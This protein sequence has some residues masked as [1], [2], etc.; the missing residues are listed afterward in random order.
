MIIYISLRMFVDTYF[1]FIYEKFFT[2]LIYIVYK[3]CNLE[4]S[5]K[6]S[7]VI[8]ISYAH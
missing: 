7:N 4:D 6:S 3:F 8:F 2:G 5:L 1:I